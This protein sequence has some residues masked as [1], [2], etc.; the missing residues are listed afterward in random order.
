MA[1]IYLLSTQLGGSM[2]KIPIFDNISLDF[3]S[4]YGYFRLHLT[5]KEANL[6]KAANTRNTK[7][8]KQQD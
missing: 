2:E 3:S 1:I 4:K 8:T 5:A 7:F 6:T